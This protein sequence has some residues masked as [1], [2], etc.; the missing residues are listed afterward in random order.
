MAD[1]GLE[2]YCVQ[3]EYCY[4]RKWHISSTWQQNLLLVFVFVLSTFLQFS[5]R[6]HDSFRV[7]N[8]WMFWFGSYGDK[9]SVIWL[10]FGFV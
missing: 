7:G 4:V 1:M 6:P 5:S 9:L 3:I 8:E 10:V 2:E